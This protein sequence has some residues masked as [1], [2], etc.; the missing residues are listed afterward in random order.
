LALRSLRGAP[1]LEGV[2]GR[3]AIDLD[4]VVRAALALADFARDAGD[5]VAEVDVNPL[6]AYPNGAVAVDALIIPKEKKTHHGDTESAEK[7]S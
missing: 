4:A 6:I 5:L 7:N 2:R 1:L 3:P